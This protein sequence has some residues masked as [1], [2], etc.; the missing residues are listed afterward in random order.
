MVGGGVGAALA[1]AVGYQFLGD[2][3]NLA[4]VGMAARGLVIGAVLAWICQRTGFSRP[5]AAAA[6]AGV[7]TVL[8]ILTSHA[9]A[10]Q[11]ERNEH[12]SRAEDLRQLRASVGNNAADLDT[13]YQ[14]AMAALSWD[15]YWQRYFGLQGPGVDG[16]ANFLGP[17]FGIGL[18]SLELIVA[19]LVA[20]YL[21]GGRASEPICQQCGAW[22]E[23]E[24]LFNT[25]FGITQTLLR[26]LQD[27]RDGRAFHKLTANDTPEF[28]E[29]SLAQCPHTHEADAGVLRFREHFFARQGR[30]AL[31]RHRADLELSPEERSE[32]DAAAARLA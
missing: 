11:H 9:L 18:F 21:P 20:M 26:E 14:H 25:T 16:A 17:A 24:S 1:L 6:I 5:R 28:L 13:D 22:L 12:E 7:A 2:L 15:R 30:R 31:R 29:L 32:L 19:I 23:E 4:F 27:T 3:G 8:S 10:F